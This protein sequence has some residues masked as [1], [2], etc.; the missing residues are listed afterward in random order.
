M[1]AAMTAHLRQAT[2][3]FM[4]GGPGAPGAGQPA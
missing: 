1:R 4:P 2:E 3:V